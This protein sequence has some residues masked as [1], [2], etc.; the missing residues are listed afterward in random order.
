MEMKYMRMANE[1]IMALLMRLLWAA[2]LVLPVFGARADVV[3]TN[4]YSF[5]GTN[6]GAVP[7]GL[8]QGNDGYLYG[9]TAWGGTTGGG[10]VF[11]ISTNGVLTTLYSFGTGLATNLNTPDGYGPQG[12]LVQGIDGYL[13]GTTQN[14]GTNNL[15][16]VFRIK[17]NGLL[18]SLYSFADTYDGENPYAG[19]VQ[20]SDGLLYGTTT[21]GGTN[22]F[23]TVFKISTNGALTTLYSFGSVL[24]T[25]DIPLD[26]FSPEAGLVQG[27]DGYL[28]GTTTQGG[29]GLNGTS[30]SPVGDGTLFKISTNGT[31][32]SLYSFLDGSPLSGLMQGSDGYLYGT[33]FWAVQGFSGGTLFK[34]STNGTF[35]SLYSLGSG[36]PRGTLVQGNDGNFYG[37]ISNAVFRLTPSGVLTPGAGM[38]LSGNTLYGTSRNGGSYGNGTM[39]SVFI[40]P[41]LTLIP[42]AANVILTW[43]TNYAGFTLQS[44]TNLGS[45]AA[46]STNLPSPFT[47]NGQ[48]TV[49]N[50]ISGTQQLFRLRQ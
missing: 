32:T 38:V 22:N 6:D 39:F 13:Y 28:Y 27:S 10:T 47:V 33:T 36:H 9:T 25:N 41:L 24:D 15:G 21:Q 3:F 18:T 16:T 19:L 37:M 29:T 48:N 40:P 17:T 46:W 23:G 20:G 31:F 35:T 5:T 43:P 45:S 12:G 44:T 1:H 42:S 30:F 50:P 4:L 49:T 8:V 26:G 11:R 14:G 34:I 7:T 2:V